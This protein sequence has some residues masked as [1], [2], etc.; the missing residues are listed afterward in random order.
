MEKSKINYFIDLL[1]LISFVINS[2]T[3]LII[4]FFLPTGI[5]RG[6]YQEFL[7]IIKQNWVDVHN[8]SGILFLLL[9]VIHLIL[10]WNW[11][12]SKTK[13]FIKKEEKG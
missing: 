11:I 13:S 2:F 1:M 8:W 12:V 7:G 6:G 3:G 5:R 9:V 10:H 4:F